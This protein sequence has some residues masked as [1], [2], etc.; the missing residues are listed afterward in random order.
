LY[1]G[2]T[3][4]YTIYGSAWLAYTDE[5]PVDS[6]KD[7]RTVLGNVYYI[8]DRKGALPPGTNKEDFVS[9]GEDGDAE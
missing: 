8:L 4:T 3:R 5:R 9:Y 1:S 2:G 7:E 6:A